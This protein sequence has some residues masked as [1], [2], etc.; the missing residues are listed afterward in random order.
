MCQLWPGWGGLLLGR[1]TYFGSLIEAGVRDED[2]GWYVV[3]TNPKLAAFYG[4][5]QWTQIDWEQRQRLR[6]KPLA[7]WLHGFYASH[8]APIEIQ[9]KSSLFKHLANRPNPSPPTLKRGDYWRCGDRPTCGNVSSGAE[10]VLPAGTYRVEAVSSSAKMIE[11][12][13]IKPRELTQIAF[14]SLS[15]KEDLNALQTE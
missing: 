12:V 13:E 9:Q 6:G 7:L 2:T 8:N 10:I 14:W 5:T 15:D 1:R 3:E 11:N 4:R